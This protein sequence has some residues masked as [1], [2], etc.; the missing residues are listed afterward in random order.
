MNEGE[1][2]NEQFW[3]AW[4]CQQ[5]LTVHLSPR[6]QQVPKTFIHVSISGPPVLS[7][8]KF[9]QHK[10]HQRALL[11]NVFPSNTLLLLLLCGIPERKLIKT[12]QLIAVPDKG[13]GNMFHRVHRIFKHLLSMWFIP[14]CKLFFRSKSSLKASC[15]SAPQLLQ[16]L[17]VLVFLF[18]HERKPLRSDGGGSR[19]DF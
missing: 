2:V 7:L 15:L 18:W 4:K 8:R 16:T 19:T 5:L 13:E 12:R 11:T 3:R 1:R 14:D 10:R 6:K 17:C 9:W